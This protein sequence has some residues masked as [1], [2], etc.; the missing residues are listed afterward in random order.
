PARQVD[1]RTG[2]LEALRGSE[3]KLTFT[4]NQ[5]VAEATLV[6]TPDISELAGTPVQGDDDDGRSHRVVLEAVGGGRFAGTVTLDRTQ[7]YYLETQQPGEA[8]QQTLVYT[9]RAIPDAAPDVQLS[10]IE[11]RKSAMIE[12]VLPLEIAATDDI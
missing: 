7:R 4:L 10:G 2:D 9:L 12:Q 1:L 3:A 6:L 5:A 11:D 8:A